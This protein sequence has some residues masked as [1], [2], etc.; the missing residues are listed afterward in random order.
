MFEYRIDPELALAL[1]R[2]EYDAA[3]LFALV[4]Q[5]RTVLGRYLPWVAGMQT[6][7]Q[8]AAFLQMT[9]E[10]YAAHQSLN[11]VVHYQ[12]EQAGMISFNHLDHENHAADIGYWLGVAYQGQN[13]MHRAVSGMCALGFTDLALH[14]LV[15][16][17]AVDNTASNRVAQ[18]AGFTLEGVI[19][20]NELLADGYHDE[21][22]YSRLKTD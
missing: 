7:A 13:I 4:Q 8:E 12:D 11:L 18:K 2:P 16:R 15:I 10:H 17:A 14:R 20:D 3:P 19:R 9:L 21:N 1:P 5:D 6:A 22:Q